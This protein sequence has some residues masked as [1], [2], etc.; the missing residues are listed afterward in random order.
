MELMNQPFNG[1]L[2]NRLIELLESQDYHTLNIVVAFAKNSGVLR[3]KD[4]LE[5]FRVKG[6]KVNV[7]VGVDLNVTSYEALTALLLCTDSLNVVH[8]E[9]K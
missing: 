6:G 1:Q 7:F 8:S 9:K 3:M 4:A 5:N 2:G